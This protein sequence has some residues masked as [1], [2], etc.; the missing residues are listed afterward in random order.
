MDNKNIRRTPDDN[1][2]KVMGNGDYWEVPHT[3]KP[4]RIVHLRGGYTCVQIASVLVVLIAIGLILFV[5][6]QR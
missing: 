6:L 4:Q 3:T 5:L 1:V 2:R